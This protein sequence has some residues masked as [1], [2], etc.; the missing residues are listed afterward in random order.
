M[1]TLATRKPIAFGKLL[2]GP[3][4]R[5]AKNRLPWGLIIV[6]LA[7]VGAAFNQI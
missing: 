7:V 6:G 4:I 5:K 1:K 3:Y 2:E